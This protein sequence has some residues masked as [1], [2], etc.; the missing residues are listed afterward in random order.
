M[1]K[2]LIVGNGGAAISAVRAVRSI[3][4]DDEITIISKESSLA[5]SPAL[6]IYYL[7]GSIRYRDMFI[8]DSSFYP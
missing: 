1:K 5:Y 4:S 7:S 3:R 2:H 8:C 6:T